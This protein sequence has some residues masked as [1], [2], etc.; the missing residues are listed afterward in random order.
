MPD[1]PPPTDSDGSFPNPEEQE[2]QI[3]PEVTAAAIAG[4]LGIHVEHLPF[5]SI[6]VAAP[7]DKQE[8]K[9]VETSKTL[10]Y[11]KDLFEIIIAR[12]KQPSVQ[13]NQAVK[14]AK[15]A[16]IYFLDDDSVP[17]MGNLILAIERFKDAEVQVVGGPN[18]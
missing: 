17:Y 15:G 18:L 13:R 8:I 3:K 2:D 1:S 10:E 16:L 6:V 7:P 5:I 14:E 11:P 9:S 12:G 4:R